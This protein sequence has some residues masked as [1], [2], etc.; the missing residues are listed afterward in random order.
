MEQNYIYDLISVGAHP[1]DAEV[2]S[3]GLLIDLSK[4]GNKCGIVILTKGEMGT[5]GD[6]QIRQEEI[7]QAAEIMGADVI[8]SF[9]WG[10]TSLSDS[11]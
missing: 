8:E 10:Y 1:D 4:R 5:G 9:N 11:Y 3:G 7:R 6:E 2:G